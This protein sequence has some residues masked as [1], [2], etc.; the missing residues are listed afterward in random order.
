[1][2]CK[3]HHD[4]GISVDGFVLSGPGRYLKL[5]LA[6]EGSLHGASC[7]LPHCIRLPRC[8]DE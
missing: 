5:S 8:D 4:L 6:L 7:N 1:M 3:V 2:G